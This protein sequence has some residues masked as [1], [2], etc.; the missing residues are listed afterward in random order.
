MEGPGLG[1]I[2]PVAAHQ[3]PSLLRLLDREAD[4]GK[5]AKLRRSRHDMSV[6]A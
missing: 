6:T 1:T 3:Q 5:C 2:D 4:V